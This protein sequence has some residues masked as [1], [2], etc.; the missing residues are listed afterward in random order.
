MS[1]MLIFILICA[2]FAGGLLVARFIGH[3]LKE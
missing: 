1:Y 2:W 3:G